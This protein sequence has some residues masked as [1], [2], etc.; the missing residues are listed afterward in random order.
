MAFTYLTKKR[1]YWLHQVPDERFARSLWNQAIPF[2]CPQVWELTRDARRR[3]F[4]KL[5]KA[6][7]R[8]EVA[9]GC[10]CELPTVFSYKMSALMHRDFGYWVV[11]LTEQV[12]KV[13]AYVLF[14][15]YDSLRLSWVSP[16]LIAAMKALDL[17]FVLGIQAN[18][19]E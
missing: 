7:R 16:T 9:Q 15:V 14:D 8:F 19:D 13:A 6:W 2:F 10:N 5:I 1:D 11:A 3:G 18:V 4:C 17:S 12:C